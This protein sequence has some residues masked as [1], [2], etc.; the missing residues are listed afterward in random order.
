VE[1][2]SAITQEFLSIRVTG[3]TV[4][5]SKI[6]YTI[7]CNDYE[8]SSIDFG[9]QVFRKAAE[10][11][12]QLRKSKEYYPVYITDIDV[13]WTILGFDSVRQFQTVRYLQY[14]QKIE[15]RLNL[16]FS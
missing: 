11:V 1:V 5:K 16:Y 12:L 4:D 8:L 7:Y 15:H 13:P 9:E 3:L 14:K 10:Y 6:N 2:E